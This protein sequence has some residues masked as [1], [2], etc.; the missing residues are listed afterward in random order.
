M[1]SSFVLRVSLLL[2]SQCHLNNNS[3]N[4]VEEKTMGILL[5]LYEAV[6]SLLIFN[7]DWQVINI[8]INVILPYLN[9]THPPSND[10]NIYPSNT[11]PNSNQ[12]HPSSNK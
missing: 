8:I 12:Y 9:L 6:H 1:L 10:N 4:K 5:Q 2:V 7:P 11:L 3:N